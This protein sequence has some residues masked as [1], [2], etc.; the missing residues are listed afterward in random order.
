MNEAENRH[1]LNHLLRDLADTLDVPPSKYAEAK[2]HYRAVGDWLNADDSEL[3]DFSP[4]IYAQGSF[5][6]GTAVRPLGDDEYDVDAVCLLDLTDSQVTQSELKEMVGR[7]L[8]HPSSR[9]KDKIDP[10]DGG[11]RC[12]TI[13]YADDSQFHLDVLP[14]LPDRPEWLRAGSV[15]DDIAAHAIRITDTET[16]D[17]L[18][19]WP[20]EG[21]GAHDPTRSNPKGYATWFKDRM[22]VR[23]D[24]AKASLAI[25]KRASVEDIEDYEVRTPLQRVI[26]V[27]KRHR[28]VRYNGGDDRPISIIITTL[29]ANAYDNEANLYEA[30]LKIVPGMRQHIE[31]RD[32]VWWVPNPVNPLENFADKWEESPR[33]AKLFF[34]WLDAV[35]AE[36][37]H[38]ITDEGFRKVG[39]YLAESY[40]QRTGREAMTKYASR[41]TSVAAPV[42]IVPSKASEATRP[43]V[44]PSSKPSKPWSC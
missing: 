18:I 16:P 36:Y 41:A 15:D 6:L 34:E 44:E 20:A 14:A 10:E 21:H 9:Y 27:L 29:A 11:R 7:R 17:Y 38:L 12:W 4:E 22:R 19:G 26:Q 28:D 39:T 42:V 13:Q 40:G 3:A 35:E 5:A 33:K 43:R 8:K 37:Q 31:D 32:G 23:L 24:E 2:D 30:I 25:E 1:Q